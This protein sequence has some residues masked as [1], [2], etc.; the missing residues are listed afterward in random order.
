MST[1]ERKN[2]KTT[3]SR[4][5]TAKGRQA[6]RTAQSTAK[7]EKAAAE[8]AAHDA[9]EAAESGARSAST[10]TRRAGRAAAVGIESGR[11]AA[12]AATGKVATTAGATWAVLKHRKA[13]A[14]GAGAGLVGVAG[15]AFAAGRHTAKAKAGPLTGPLTRLTH[16]RI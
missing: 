3:D 2:A 4:A 1:E 10:A 7:E 13:I 14:A 11:Q 15:A 16:G 5:M 12:V 6:A 8:S 9:R